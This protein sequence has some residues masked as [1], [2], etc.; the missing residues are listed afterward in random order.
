MNTIK[1]LSK[2]SIFII[3]G[4]ISFYL[5]YITGTGTILNYIDFAD[6]LNEMGFFMATA[7]MGGMLLYCGF[8]K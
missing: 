2:N 5:A 8:S 1:R 7:S 6:P 4:L 3:C